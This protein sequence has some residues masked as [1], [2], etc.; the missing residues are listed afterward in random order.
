[1]SRRIV[2]LVAAMAALVLLTGCELKAELVVS[3][4]G[5][6]FFKY[7]V[8]IDRSRLDDLPPGVDPLG[9]VRRSAAAQSFPVEVVAFDNDDE[10]GVTA[11]FEFDDPKDLRA[12]LDELHTNGTRLTS[13]YSL[14][15]LLLRKTRSG[16]WLQ[17]NTVERSRAVSDFPLD[18]DDLDGKPRAIFTATLPGKDRDEN[19]YRFRRHNGRTTFTWR[20]GPDTGLDRYHLRAETITA[21]GNGSLWPPLAVVTGLMA[22]VPL[23]LRYGRRAPAA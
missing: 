3:A 2:T 22:G 14:A 17:A 5:S 15:D 13:T 16:W 19:A 9:E 23:W 20:I 4:D 7:T 1:M 18:F 12:K 21:D 6:G 11:R 10:V 8:A